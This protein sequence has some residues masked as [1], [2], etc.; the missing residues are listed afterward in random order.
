[1]PRASSIIGWICI[2]LVAAFNIFA[3]VMKF[4]PVAPGSDAAAMQQRLGIVG[5]EYGLGVL[6]FAIIAL[7]LAPR[8]STV[9]TVLMACYMA[10]A[11]ATNLTHGF[12]HAEAIPLYVSLV[13]I[14]IGAGLRNPELTARLRGRPVPA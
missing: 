1:M 13:L 7:Y 10:G 14:A 12:S 11:L 4:V 2:G 9:G 3:A 8:T 5:L 6:E